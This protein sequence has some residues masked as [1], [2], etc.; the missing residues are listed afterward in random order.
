MRRSGEEGSR[1][2]GRRIWLMLVLYHYT[3]AQDEI[4]IY[5]IVAVSCILI[6]AY[7]KVN[8]K[9]SVLG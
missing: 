8:L 2:E 9:V 5:L 7:T 3:A 6:Y 1:G 4:D